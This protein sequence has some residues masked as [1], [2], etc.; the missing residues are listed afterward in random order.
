MAAVYHGIVGFAAGGIMR[1]F[2]ALHWGRMNRYWHVLLAL[3]G[4]FAALFLAFNA[5][6]PIRWAVVRGWYS[7]QGT[8]T[9]YRW[10]GNR[11]VVPLRAQPTPLDVRLTLASPLW[12]GR[13][14]PRVTLLA[15]TQPLTSFVVPEL[16]TTYTI[17]LP[18]DTMALVVQSTADR[19]PQ[20]D[21]R[22]LG[23]QVFDMSA[24]AQGLSALALRDAAVAFAG[25]CLVA[26]VIGWCL[27]RGYGAI[28]GLFVLALLIRLW[29][30]RVAPP[31]FTPE[32]AASL[33]DAQSLLLRARDR[34]GNVLGLAPG[35]DSAP[36]L[37]YIEMPFVAVLGPVPLAGRLVS[38][39][40]GAFTAPLAYAS[41]R[42]LN[43][44]KA[45]ALLT[46]LVAAMLPWQ[47]LVSRLAL[48]QA[49]V[50]AAWAATLYLALRFV[51]RATR[52]AALWFALVA[53]PA[54]YANDTL[55][56]ALLFL[57]I[58]V[59]LLVLLRHGKQSFARWWP[60]LA[61]LALLWLP[62]NYLALLPPADSPSASFVGVSAAALRVPVAPVSNAVPE[63]LADA[64]FLSNNTSWISLTLPLMLLG[65]G[66]VMWQLSLGFWPLNSRA[67]RMPQAA[68]YEWWIVVGAALG[69]LL[70]LWLVPGPTAALLLAPP[71]VLCVGA[72]AVVIEWASQ[73]VAPE[74]WQ[75]VLSWGS[76]ALLAVFLLWPWARWLARDLMDGTPPAGANTQNGLLEASA[77]AASYAA[78]AD[79]VWIDTDTTVAP[80]LYLLAAQPHP[81][82]R[83]APAPSLMRPYR[84]ISL[85]AVPRELPLLEVVPDVQGQTSFVLQRWEHDGRQIILLR[86]MPV[87]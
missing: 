10:M 76:M 74:Q 84:F 8:P 30:L 29:W 86:R 50:L 14:A 11:L 78:Q 17:T 45:P 53:G 25:L 39:C 34:F 51:R 59:I 79:E 43:L 62:V 20:G 71:F 38:A 13:A 49:L 3:F 77:L 15:D 73:R 24:Q 64:M 40:A 35:W 69:G 85:A 6:P 63:D 46:G 27:A 9:P 72:G 47:I 44:P 81:I 61:L 16:P 87:Q 60:G 31:G 36:L 1:V 21:E 48:P 12:P 26:A 67:E 54:A 33:I 70:A 2:R 82:G 22:Y 41:A 18:I 68:R 37:A 58:W 80:A 7:Q 5:R 56:P 19:A 55:R 65:L 52:R 66:F 42:R 23:I 57:M 4:L 28:A 32:E 83:E 75:R